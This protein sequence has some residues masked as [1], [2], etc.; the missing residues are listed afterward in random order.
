M[1]ARQV[2]AVLLALLLALP[3]WGEPNVVGNVVSSRSASVRG[4]SLTPG[5]TILSGDT[6]DVGPQGRAWITLARGAQVYVSE[7][8]LV[9]LAKTPD[10]IQLTVHRGGASFRTAEKS[11]VEA[12]LGDATV[13]S[14]DGLP[15]VGIINVRDSQ[16]GVIAAEKG[17]LLITTEHDSKS[18]TLRE[19][20][21]AEVTLVPQQDTDQEKEKKKKKRG[22]AAAGTVPGGSL[23]AGKAVIIAAIVGGATVGIAVWLLNREPSNTVQ[24]NCNAVSPFRCP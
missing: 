19:G 8:S 18:V 3:A 12:L 16:S 23:T 13:R 1:F 20:E 14:A 2:L 17:T 24:S 9:S 10:E 5:S 7:N 21:G 4:A 6:I 22:A 11:P 15:A